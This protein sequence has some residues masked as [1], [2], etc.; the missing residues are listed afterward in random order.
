MALIQC[1]ECGAMISDRAESCPKCGAPTAV[2]SSYG[3]Q[4]AYQQPHPTYPTYETTE[5]EDSPSVGLN[6]LAF[7]IPLVGW[8]LYFVLKGRTPD[9]A[10][11]CAIAAWCGFAVGFCLSLFSDL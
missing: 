3:H 9:K 8:I 4:S 6:I 10:R 11:S 7:L 2:K 1:T 5:P